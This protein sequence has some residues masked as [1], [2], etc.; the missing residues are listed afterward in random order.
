MTGIGRY[1]LQLARHLAQRQEIEELLFSHGRN[2]L[3]HVPEPLHQPASISRLR[4]HFSRYD[5]LLD[6]FRKA[7]SHLK[8]RSIRQRSAHVY[9]GTNYYLPE[10]SGKRVVTI[11]DLSIFSLPEYH[12][13]D[14]V[15]YLQRE[16]LLSLR[17]ANTIVTVSEFSKR[18][19]A[20]RFDWPINRIHVTPLAS[21]EVFHP[22]SESDLTPFLNRRGLNTYGYCL[23]IG[24]IEPRKNL[25]ALLSAYSLLPQPLRSRFPLVLAGDPGWNSELLHARIQSAARKGWLHYLDFVPDTQL[26]ALLAGARLFVFPSFYEGFGLPVIE[27]MASGVP[28]VCA[29]TSSL[30]EV[31]GDAAAMFAPH[32]VEH[33]ST[34]I[35]AAFEDE[36]W[37]AK[38]KTRGLLRAKT[39]SWERCAEL[40]LGA[41]TAATLS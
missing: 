23:Y 3:R 22:R 11:H 7:R 14:R 31:A 32:D 33:L 15:R 17:R 13:P 18:Q 20:E 28:V 39:F 10:F 9:H 16:M 36:L 35:A 41:Y 40:T 24:T 5:L 25:D 8:A 21:A 27:A 34:L 12:R 6:G 30:P 2:L 38:A 1:T 29:N 26:P 19:I 37:H 4:D